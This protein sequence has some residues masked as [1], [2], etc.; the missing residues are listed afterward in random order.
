VLQAEVAL[1]SA[2]ELITAQNNYRISKITLAKSLRP[3]FQQGVVKIRRSK[4]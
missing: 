1:Q 4:W 3:R 2:S